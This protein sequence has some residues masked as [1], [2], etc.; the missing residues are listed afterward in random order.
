MNELQKQNNSPDLARVL[1]A[2]EPILLELAAGDIAADDAKS[3][4]AQLAF[5]LNVMLTKMAKESSD[6]S[7]FN[8]SRNIKMKT[9]A[10]KVAVLIACMLASTAAAQSNDRTGNDELKL[11]AVEALITAPDDRALPLVQKVL[12]GNNSAE[13]KE[14]ALFILSQIKAPEA[15]SA[16]LAYAQ[17]ANGELQMEAIRMM[18]INGGANIENLQ[19]IYDSGN[20]KTRKAVLEAFMI[21]GDKKAVFE[22]A[23]VAEGRDFENAV[24]MLAVMG[25]RDEIREL[26]SSKGISEAIIEACAV[27]GDFACLSELAADKSNA[28]LQAEAIEAMGIIG[29]AEVN[30]ALV[31]IYKSANNE[32][33]REAARDGLL[34]SGDD[35][36]LLE[37]YR[38]SDTPREKK[39]L[40]EYLVRTD[41]DEV[42]SIIDAALTGDD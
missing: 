27:S 9:L 1:R 30:A 39:E 32:K 37:L 2:F 38:A 3:L 21:S 8:M 23:K 15:Q 10:S 33:I 5:E 31:D 41:S 42:W 20:G 26:K 24:E 4:R 25:A 13:V 29:G 6:Q 7:T 22:I 19:G 14:A 40:L 28:K 17:E 36:G 34:I 16:V 11:A 12:A 18:G 35:Q